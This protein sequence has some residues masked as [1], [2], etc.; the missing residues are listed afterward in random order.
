MTAP[1][2]ATEPSGQP[3]PFAALLSWARRQRK[4]LLL[5]AIAGVASYV[6]LADLSLMEFKGDEALGH[7]RIV[8]AARDGRWPLATD[9]GSRDY[10]RPAIFV[11]LMALSAFVSSDPVVH[12]GFV[13]VLG[14]LTVA[15][16]FLLAWRFFG[17]TAAVIA[18]LLFAVAPWAVIYS[19]KIWV[20]DLVP[21][22]TTL[23]LFGLFRLAEAPTSRIWTIALPVTIITQA[24][25]Y[26][27]GLVA[28]PLGVA[29]LAYAAFRP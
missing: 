24:S 17:S 8:E 29:L 15:L 20:P 1:A 21:I 25:L 19:R 13:A 7:Q 26:D 3:R 27:P 9:P 18:A 23:T 4:W 16:C 2:L 11:Y 12:A 22:F 5:A 6:R 14:I 10:R 28:V